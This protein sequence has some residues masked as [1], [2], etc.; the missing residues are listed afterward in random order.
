MVQIDHGIKKLFQLINVTK[1]SNPC[2]DQFFVKHILV[3]E[4][5]NAYRKQLIKFSPNELFK[6]EGSGAGLDVIYIKTIILLQYIKGI[7]FSTNSA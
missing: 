2:S 3:A 4:P 1:T 6:T 5:N 7:L